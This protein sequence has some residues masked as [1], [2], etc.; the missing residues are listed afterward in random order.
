MLNLIPLKTGKAVSRDGETY[1]NFEIYDLAEAREFVGPEGDLADVSGWS[2][3][4][5][6]VGRVFR[7]EPTAR[8]YGR[9]V[10]VKQYVGRDV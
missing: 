5:G 2:G 9:K 3:Y 6:G 10:I 7:T 8:V 1:T 4:H